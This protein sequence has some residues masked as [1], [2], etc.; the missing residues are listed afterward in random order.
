MF[1][2]FNMY[3]WKGRT[4]NIKHFKH[5]I[6]IHCTYYCENIIYFVKKHTI[7][8][9]LPPKIM[10]FWLIILNSCLCFYEYSS[11]WGK[12]ALSKNI[13]I[14]KTFNMNNQWLKTVF[15]L[16]ANKQNISA[17]LFSLFRNCFVPFPFYRKPVDKE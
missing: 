2:L 15:P 3:I 11:C 8:P 12:G 5:I 13:P 6:D 17:I 10:K 14:G 4:L 16:S 9:V 1:C 7:I